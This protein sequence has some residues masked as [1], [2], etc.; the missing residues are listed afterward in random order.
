MLTRLMNLFELGAIIA[1]LAIALLLQFYFHELPCPLCLLQ[2]IGFLMIAFGFLLNLKFGYRPFHYTIVLLSALFTA[3]VALR[4]I[5]L[6]VLPGAGAYGAPFLGLHLYTWSFIASMVI[7]IVTSIVLG[8]GWQYH[9][10][11]YQSTLWYLMTHLLFVMVGLILAAN[12]GA[13][14]FECGFRVCPDNPIK[15]EMLI[16]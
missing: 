1:I 16:R 9:A 2:R 5:A 4:Q 15:Y 11:Q 14:I 7:I 13:V 3:F 10:R 12:I 8:M 6:H